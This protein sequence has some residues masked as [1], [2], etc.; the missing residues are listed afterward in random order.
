MTHTKT[1]VRD[2][3]AAEVRSLMGRHRVSQTRLATA[4]G[5][6]QSALSRRLNGEKAFDVDDL[7]T[8][9]EELKFE[10]EVDAMFG[11]PKSAWFTADDLRPSV[12][13]A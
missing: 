7:A 8:I 4:L 11:R 13:A 5:M 12:A 3:V 1:P 9:A 10:L 2:E 6:S